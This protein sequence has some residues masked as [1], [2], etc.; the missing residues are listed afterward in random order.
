MVGQVDGAKGTR[1][2]ERQHAGGEERSLIKGRGEEKGRERLKRKK[3]KS[4][5]GE[6]KLIKGKG[7]EK[8]EMKIKGR[9]GRRRGRGAE[10]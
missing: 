3:G 4:Q 9:G 5:R 2:G 7:G 10:G 6:E 1:N 8:I